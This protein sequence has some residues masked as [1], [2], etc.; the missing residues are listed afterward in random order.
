MNKTPLVKNK[1][2]DGGN[3]TKTT[4]RLNETFPVNNNIPNN[5]KNI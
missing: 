2:P 1:I 4:R 5:D 3:T